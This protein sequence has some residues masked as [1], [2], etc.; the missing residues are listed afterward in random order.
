MVKGSK[1]VTMTVRLPRRMAQRIER[2]RPYVERQ[3]AFAMTSNVTRS[4]LV[5]YV[6]LRGLEDVEEAAARDT[7]FAAE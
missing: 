7:E 4:D 6:L 1:D 2:L 3:R 5:R